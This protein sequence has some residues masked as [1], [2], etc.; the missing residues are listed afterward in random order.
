VIGFLDCYSGISGDMLLGAMVDA[1]LPMQ[2]LEAVVDALRLGGDVSVWAETVDRSGLRAT[3]VHVEAHGV[4]PHRTLASLTDVLEASSL[5]ERVRASSLA[6]LTAIAEVEGRIHGRPTEEVELHELGAV[7]SVI[8][9]VGAAA[10]L[11]ALDIDT[12]Y[13]S[14]LPVSP[15]DIVGV[16]DR[17]L[18]GPA[19]ATL[20]LLAAARAPVRPFGE[21]RELVTPTGAALVTTLA[22]FG[23][24]AMRVERIGYGAGSTE[25]P[26]PNVL[27]LWVGV[28]LA[29]ESSIRDGFVVLE[30]N[31]DDMSPQLLAPATEILLGAGALDV[32]VSPLFMKKG[33]AGWLLTVIARARDESMLADLLLRETTTLGVRVHRV[34]RYEAQR[35]QVEVDT[36]Y[37]RVAVKLKLLEGSVVGAVPE[38]ESV[39]ETAVAAHARLSAVH[40]AASAA[41]SELLADA[42][43]GEVVE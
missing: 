39:R 25:M 34:G 17:H 14:A 21:G 36:R 40:A 18:P 19:P 43:R 2:R 23:Q 37:G 26:W 4:Q 20:A 10:G 32:A 22:R 15:G 27:R 35:R 5:P 30:T 16:H 41:A 12:L 8:D 33:R 3:S 13:A 38:F 11:A 6:V 31:L 29:G 1:G 28:P 9:V 7:D 24:P 42:I